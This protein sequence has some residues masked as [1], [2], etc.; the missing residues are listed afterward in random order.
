MK[1][2]ILAYILIIGS[3]AMLLLNIF[4]F[5]TKLFSLEFVLRTLWSILIIIIGI[6][7][8]KENK[9]NA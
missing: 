5:D 8:I 7:F 1:K 4:Y 9:N 2:D 3:T 6:T